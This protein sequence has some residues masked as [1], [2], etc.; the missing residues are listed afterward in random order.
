[1]NKRGVKRRRCLRKVARLGCKIIFVANHL[2]KRIKP[3]VSVYHIVYVDVFIYNFKVV[4]YLFCPRT[5][6]A[7][8]FNRVNINLFATKNQVAVG[9]IHVVILRVAAV[10]VSAQVCIKRRFARA[11]SFKFY[12]FVNPFNINHVFAA[13]L[14]GINLACANVGKFI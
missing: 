10:K 14:A 13:V 1:M 9:L 3:L 7:Q 8:V 6:Y 2:A 12:K 4:G 11:V 5:R